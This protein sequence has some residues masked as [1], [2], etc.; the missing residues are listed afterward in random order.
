MLNCKQ[1]QGQTVDTY[2]E[3][4][5][6][7]ADTIEFHGGS[8]GENYELIEEK[9]KNGIKRSVADRQKISRD[10]TLA[11]IF[12]RNLDP[13]R[14]GTLIAELANNYA[15]G[16]DEYPTDL[17]AAHS[18]VVNYRTPAN[19]RERQA[20]QT[21]SHSVTPP[22]VQQGVS[23]TMKTPE[24]SAM[25]FAQRA[26]APKVPGTDGITHN[27]ITCFLCQ[28]VGHSSTDCPGHGATEKSQPTAGNP[29]VGGKTLMQVA[30]MLA[31]ANQTDRDIDPNWI[32]LDSQSTVSVF[33]NPN[34]LTNI[35]DS[36]R[37]LRA[38]TNRVS[39]T[40]PWSATFQTLEKSGTTRNQLRTSSLSP[41]FGKFVAL[42]WT[43][44]SV[45]L[46]MSTGLTDQP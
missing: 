1:Q 41:M 26:A 24:G 21:Q 44:P 2:L 39:R 7:W 35:R 45:P 17:E 23:T 31:Q 25:T 10:R 29:G 37:V 33:C 30:Y 13:T 14:Y 16:R 9:D 40:L 6:G 27:T 3:T 42:P 38:L 12:T 34:M 4:L 32:L 46:S 20:T 19:A 15:R 36:G 22:P 18:M 28:S 5:K 43:P 11:A 8:V